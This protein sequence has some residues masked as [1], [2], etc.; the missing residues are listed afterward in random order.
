MD[1]GICDPI[2][3]RQIETVVFIQVRPLYPTH[4]LGN[5]D[6]S[7]LKVL[8]CKH[9]YMPACTR[10]LAAFKESS[11]ASFKVLFVRTCT[12]TDVLTLFKLRASG[13]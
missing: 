12:L 9:A 5:G 13:V 8:P 6:S 2:E 7:H 11:E 3:R 1:G 4:Q 10:Q